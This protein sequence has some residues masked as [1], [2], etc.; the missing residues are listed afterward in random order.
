MTRHRTDLM[1]AAETERLLCDLSTSAVSRPVFRY[2][3]PASY[4]RN[5]IRRKNAKS[6]GGPRSSFTAFSQ[7]QRLP[8]L[9]NARVS[10]GKSVAE[11]KRRISQQKNY[12]NKESWKSAV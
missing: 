8:L 2:L 12:Q 5:F 10:S 6:V 7:P 11:N 1:L 4:E 9:L 3:R